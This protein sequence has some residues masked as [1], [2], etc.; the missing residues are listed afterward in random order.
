MQV[1]YSP[2]L[3]S[4]NKTSSSF[5]NSGAYTSPGTPD[6]GDNNNNVLAFQK[7]W[8]SER[9]P[10]SNSS[11]RHI[12]AAALMP[13]NSGRTLP[14]KWDDAERWITSPVS[15]FGV[16]KTLA[17]PK[18]PKA[19]SG[20]LGGTTPGVAYYSNYSP[21]VP[22]L[23]GG[24]SR[25]FLAG[26]P[27]TT[28]VLVP[29][30]LHFC[31]AAGGVGHDEKI[32]ENGVSRVVSRRDMA[33]QMSPESS[34]E[35]SPTYIIPPPGSHHSAR[36][37]VRD[38]QVDKRVTMTKQSKRN[39]MRMRNNGSPEAN[40]LALTWN[41]TEGAMKQ[42]KLQKEEAR[43]TAWENLQNAKAEASIR[44]LEMKLEKKKSASMDKIL[45]KHRAAQLKAQEMRRN[46][47]ESVA[48]RTRK[49][50]T[51]RRHVTDSL[52]GCFRCHDS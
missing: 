23:E 25:N 4:S 45:N 31:D 38:V 41:A 18:R 28:G 16:C 49:F 27:L 44:K 40:E 2:Q 10:L 33:T 11:R 6:Y 3:G 35:P 13:F 37:E 14:S 17:P 43:I 50:R 52:T 24:S 46:M 1:C 12:S 20:P 22:A 36:L 48:P 30:G 29:E 8:C 9:I 32:D 19:K 39:K 34:P 7:G 26:S 15:N 47:S 42:S 21:A 5:R 51:L